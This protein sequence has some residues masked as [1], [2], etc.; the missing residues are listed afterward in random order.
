MPRRIKRYAEHFGGSGALLLGGPRRRGVVEV[1][2]DA[3]GDLV[4]LFAC[5]KCRPLALLRE[6]DFLPLHSEQDFL[7][8]RGLME[9]ILTEPD[10]SYSEMEIAREFFAGQQLAELMAILRRRTE[11]FDVRRA[12][13][14]YIVNRSSFNGTMNSFG[15]KPVYFRRFLDDIERAA[16]R[17]EGVPILHRDFAD[18]VKLND[19][20]DTLHYFDPPYYE[21][22]GMYPLPFGLRDHVRVHEAAQM[23]FGYSVISYNYHDFICDLFSDMYILKFERNNE[24]AQKKGAKYAEVIITNYD[25]RPVM[26]H[27]Q[28]QISMFG[29]PDLEQEKAKLLLI[30]KPSRPTRH[31]E[32]AIWTP[33]KIMI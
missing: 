20:P 30:N 21:A 31:E 29:P 11:L 32:L 33:N 18:S 27:N 19:T 26:E 14:F 13:A 9:H 8:L 6:L 4:N 16:Y 5:V 15:A 7:C 23:T 22:E 25:P 28:A 2:N 24:M 10:F 3:N 17:L 12:A 1:Y